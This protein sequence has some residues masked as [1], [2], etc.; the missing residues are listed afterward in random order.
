MEIV[1]VFTIFNPHFTNVV[2]LFRH[3]LG[4]IHRFITS[5]LCSIDVCIYMKDKKVRCRHNVDQ[6]CDVEDY[7]EVNKKNDAQYRL[8]FGPHCNIDNVGGTLQIII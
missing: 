1:V 4:E 8:D 6:H 7:D 5:S 2:S 3:L